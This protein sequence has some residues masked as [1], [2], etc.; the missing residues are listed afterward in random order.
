MPKEDVIEM[1]GEVVENLPNGQVRAQGKAWPVGGPEPAAWLIDKTDPIGNREGAPGLFLDAQYG[2]HLDNFALT[3]NPP[4]GPP[5]PRTPRINDVTER[6]KGRA[7]KPVRWQTYA[8]TSRSTVGSPPGS[9]ARV[10]D[11]RSAGPP[12]GIRSWNRG[13]ADVGRHAGPQHGVGHEGA[14]D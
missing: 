1:Q 3:P 2:V 14:A 9:R 4:G 13:L 8:H 7:C 10:D 5:T 12:V 6:S 11:Y